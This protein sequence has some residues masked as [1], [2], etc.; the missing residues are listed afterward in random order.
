MKRFCEGRE[1]CL[2]GDVELVRAG[3][4]ESQLPWKSLGGLRDSNKA[5]AI[6]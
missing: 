4:L 5:K 1:N 2:N 3:G 6:K